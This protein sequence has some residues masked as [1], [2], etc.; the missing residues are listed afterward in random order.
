MVIP[1]QRATTTRGGADRA[2]IDNVRILRMGG[3]ITALA[4]AS[5]VTIAPRDDALNRVA[6]DADAGIILLRAIDAVGELVVGTDVIELGGELV[7]DRAKGCAA[8]E[9]DVGPTVITLDHTLIVLGVDPEAVII[10]VGGGNRFP[11]FAAV[12]RFPEAQVADVNGIRIL[13][14]G[15]DMQVIPG[16]V[17]QILFG[18][19]FGPAFAKVIRAVDARFFL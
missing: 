19:L 16:A 7:V 5:H 9:G 13:G 12:G 15:V 8:V 4:G 10:A 17:T 6:G 14:I 11:I 2:N 18:T 1:L 3:D